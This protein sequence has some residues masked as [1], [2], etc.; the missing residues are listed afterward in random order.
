MIKSNI[1]IKQIHLNII[2]MKM[3]RIK[4]INMNLN[5]VLYLNKDS[6]K[7]S[8]ISEVSNEEKDFELT[9][10]LDSEGFLLNEN[11]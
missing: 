3:N 7:M 1:K 9:Y 4:Q 11:E 10:Q 2:K 5:M 8:I 6:F